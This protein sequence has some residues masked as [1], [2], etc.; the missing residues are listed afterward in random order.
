MGGCYLVS[1]LNLGTEA[2]S[3]GICGSCRRA[4][5]SDCHHLHGPF[6]E[7]FSSLRMGPCFVVS[8]YDPCKGMEREVDTRIPSILW[9]AVFGVFGRLYIHA[10]PKG[11][12][13]VQRMKNA[14]WIDLVNMLL[15]FISAIYGAVLFFRLRGHKS[16][17]TGRA[18]V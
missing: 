16:L 8:D 5:C 13:G 17:H 2:D 11:A 15:W 6:S 4:V 3:I 12:S 7:I 9:V 18:T 10:D 1:G 14:V